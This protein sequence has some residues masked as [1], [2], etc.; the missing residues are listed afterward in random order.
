[1]P[2]LPEVETICRDLNGLYAGSTISSIKI[3]D[4]TNLRQI[5]PDEFTRHLEGKLIQDISRVGKMIDWKLSEDWHL[6]IHLKMTGRFY[7]DKLESDKHTK[8]LFR[9]KNTRDLYFEDTRKFAVVYLKQTADRNKLPYFAKL[10]IDPTSES[11]AIETLRSLVTRYARKSAKSF[12][13]EQHVIAG[14]GN[15]Y[16]SEILF[17]S[18]IH[19]ELP[20]GQISTKQFSALWLQIKAVLQEAIKLRGTTF[21]DYH[22]VGR[23]SGG[24]QEMLKVYGRVG[25]PCSICGEPIIRIVQQGRSTFYCNQCTAKQ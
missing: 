19:P 1:M 20:I 14:I 21:S 6:L 18:E 23:Q 5:S 13:L 7:I 9:F 11:F 17:R 15:I 16:A 12:L 2:E 4:S 22:D 3:F 25:E 10:G 24:Y 8:L